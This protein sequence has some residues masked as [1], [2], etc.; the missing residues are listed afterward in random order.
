[1]VFED[2]NKEIKTKSFLPIRNVEK[3][4]IFSRKLSNKEYQITCHT[5]GYE[6]KAWEDEC[7]HVGLDWND[8]AFLNEDEED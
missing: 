3:T 6:K 2:K 4:T 8:A 5:P 7:H 1:M